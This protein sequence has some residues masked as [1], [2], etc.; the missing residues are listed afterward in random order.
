MW[1]NSRKIKT[2]IISF[3]LIVTIFASSLAFNISTA[4]AHILIIGDSFN[5]YPLSY[6]ET[7]KLAQTLKSRGYEVLELYK[8]NAT[9]KNILKGMFNADA[10]I[11]AGHG[12]YQTG[13]YNNK[14]GSAKAP[15]AIV[16]SDSDYKWIWG[17]EDKMR[18]GW[19]GELFYAPFKPGIPVIFLHAC[20]S[21]GWV[22]NYEVANPI[23]TIYNFSRMFTGSGANYYAT[24]WN[25]AEIIYDFLNGAENFKEANL[26]NW[27]TITRSTLFNGTLIW[28]NTGGYAAF[29]GDWKG[30]FP[31]AIETTPYDNQAAEE[32]YNSKRIKSSTVSFF[33][34]SKGP[35]Y[36]NQNIT[37]FEKSHDTPYALIKYIWNWGDGNIL[38]SDTPHNINYSYNAPGI[39]V[40]N[41]TVWNNQNQSASYCR[42]IEVINRNPVVDFKFNASNLFPGTPI[43]FLSSSYD[44]D[45]GDSINSLKWNFGD[46]SS[47][48]GP[49]LTHSYNKSGNY[50]VTLTATDSFGKSSS[51]S[52]KITINP[53]KVVATPKPDLIITSSRKSGRYLYV[54]IKN[55]GSAIAK[56]FH[57]RA[58]YGQSSSKN[59]K[60]IYTSSLASGASV[61]LK[62]P[63]SYKNGSIK[64]DFFNKVSESNENNNLRKF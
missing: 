40:V 19:N 63:Y 55:Q 35:Y 41:H 20:F 12:G 24:A 5:D 33:D 53:P 22:E 48:S 44:P 23:E 28:K 45:T 56:N 46:G 34:V 11:Y 47:G 17:V 31:T 27:E 43:N 50:T 39:F 18:E 3:I 2:L 60:D 64:V 9:S 32:W 29:V 59:Y 15:F 8:E 51:K 62:V 49:S 16:T 25:G 14:G 58:W 54:T 37:F 1:N 6:S 38:Y 52:T 57:T 21:T 7:N 26:Q 13:N 42:T 30:T 36:I 4:D 61:T 10:I